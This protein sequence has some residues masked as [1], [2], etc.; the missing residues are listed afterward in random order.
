MGINVMIEAELIAETDQSWRITDG[1]VEDWIPKSI[2]EC[3][4]D[5]PVIGDVYEFEVP[6]WLCLEKGFV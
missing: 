3:S 1:D 5:G 4:E 6:E 2:C